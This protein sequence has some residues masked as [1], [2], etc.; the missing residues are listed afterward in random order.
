MDVENNNEDDASDGRRCREKVMK[1]ITSW[2]RSNLP[3]FRVSIRF[4]H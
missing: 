1:R 2:V 4:R 3:L